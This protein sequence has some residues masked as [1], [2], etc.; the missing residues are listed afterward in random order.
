[1]MKY[2]STFH[3][4]SG[5]GAHREKH[6]HVAF[7]VELLAAAESGLFHECFEFGGPHAG[8]ESWSAGG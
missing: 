5:L 8:A 2:D 7:D 3:E 1:M 6:I 4:L